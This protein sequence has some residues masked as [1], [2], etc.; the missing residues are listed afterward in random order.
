M[1][2]DA[3]GSRDPIP[4]EGD[5]RT[6][7]ATSPGDPGPST[8]VAPSHNPLISADPT[9][10]SGWAAPV[11]VVPEI[12][13]GIVIADTL[14]RFVAFLLDLVVIGFVSAVLGSILGMR[15]GSI[16]DGDFQSFLVDFDYSVLTIA[17]GLVYFVGSWSGGR[18][19]TLGQRVFR[20][21]VGNAF[22]GAALTLEQA[23]RRWLGYGHWL[24][25]FSFE[26][27]LARVSGL[28]QFV[29]LVAL[30]VT[31]VASPTKQGLHDR[32][33]NT[34]VVRP[35][36]AGR[37]LAIGC[38]LLMLVAF[39]LAVAGL[40]AFFGSDAGQDILRRAVDS[41]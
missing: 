25:L 13:P 14:S 39:A 33:A 5:E 28:V 22:D 1:D 34:A 9:P 27:G 2:E 24:V 12:A 41:V 11:R 17:V 20:L 36:T 3:K 37:G 29:W 19:A 30:L 6:T 23:V 21:Q 16:A 40:A 10:V 31:T 18:R 8:P 35:S 15:A 38:L 7:G 26:P 32:L 4:G